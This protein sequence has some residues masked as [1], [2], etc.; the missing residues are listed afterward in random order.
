R[1]QY[2]FHV[3]SGKRL[4]ETTAS[5]SVLCRFDAAGTAECWA[6]EADRLRG[7]ASATSGL[8]G[9]NRR[10]RVFAGL[11]D[12]PF[13]T[14][15]KGTRAALN[16]VGAALGRGVARDAAGCPRFDEATSTAVFEAWRHTGGGAASNFLAGW[17][18]SAL[19][20]AIDLPLVNSGGDLLAV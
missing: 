2:V 18:S 3:G 7:D 14:K 13:F 19:V 10:F 1:V 11:R 12:D 5:I 17:T 9:A 20:V 15:V 6:G 4:G 16:L 8:E